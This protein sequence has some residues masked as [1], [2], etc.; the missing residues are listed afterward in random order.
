MSVLKFKDENGIWQQLDVGADEQLVEAKTDALDSKI[1]K[2]A[3]ARIE[4]DN[5]LDLAISNEASI[6]DQT[7]LS[8]AEDITKKLDKSAIVQEIGTAEDKVISQKVTTE[9]LNEKLDKQSAATTVYAIDN[10]GKQYQLA[11]NS[12]AGESLV[13]LQQLTTKLLNYLLNDGTD[14]TFKGS[15]AIQGDLEVRGTTTT[16]KEESLA[17]KDSIIITNADGADLSAT[18]AGFVI[19]LNATDCYGILYDHSTQSVKLGKG[20]I[21]DGKFAFNAGEGNAVA[22]RADGSL[23]TDG[24]L[25]KWDAT[26]LKFVDAGK[27]ADD[28]V[29]RVK[30]ASGAQWEI[31]AESDVGQKT[32]RF[33]KTPSANQLVEYTDAKTVSTEDAKTDLDAVNLRQLTSRL[34]NVIEGAK[35]VLI[36]TLNSPMSFSQL[37]SGFY[38]A[39]NIVPHAVVESTADFNST[40]PTNAEY[41]VIINTELSDDAISVITSATA[42]STTGKIYYAVTQLNQSII[43]IINGWNE[44]ARSIDGSSVK[45]NHLLKWQTNGEQP[46]DSGIDADSVLRDIDTII[47]DCGTSTEII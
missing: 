16:T 1:D 29:S 46:V 36:S 26:A 7:D 10:N 40:L 8:L 25:V 22:V 23:M 35:D 11:Y 38:H 42:I 32:L 43:T 45:N 9:K 47:F 44:I 20:K 15:L 2:E 28:F 4:A 3:S 30:V 12:D 34:Q 24:H 5:N 27:S 18:L 37:E 19:R 41:N 21:T 33:A 6:R 17:V 14:Q 31:Y 13:I 39:S